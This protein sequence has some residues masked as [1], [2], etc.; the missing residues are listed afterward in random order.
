MEEHILSRVQ[1]AP[2]RTQMRPDR[3][4]SDFSISGHAQVPV[5]NEESSIASGHNNNIKAL[6]HGIVVNILF[7]LQR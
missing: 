2:G 6:I 5:R 1:G 7:F 3:H 4:Q